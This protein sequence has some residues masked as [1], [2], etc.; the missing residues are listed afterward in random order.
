MARFSYTEAFELPTFTQLSP[1]IQYFPDVTDIGYGTAAGGN[2]DLKPVESENWD[3]SLEWYFNEG[4]V[5]YA[6]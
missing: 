2:P 4:G 5:V 3:I 6:T 1:Y